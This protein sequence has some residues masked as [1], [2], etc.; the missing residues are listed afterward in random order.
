[1]YWFVSVITGY[2]AGDTGACAGPATH[3]RF[4]VPS[5]IAAQAGAG[6]PTRTMSISGAAT[7]CSMRACASNHFG[8]MD[9]LLSDSGESSAIPCR[10]PER[11]RLVSDW[12]LDTSSSASPRDGGH[13]FATAVDVGAGSR[14]WPPGPSAKVCQGPDGGCCAT[15]G[16]L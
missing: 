4:S 16:F 8:L 9:S 14:G 2:C 5:P 1:M 11:G 12:G 3:C 10:S 15:P 6:G 7:Q 13:H